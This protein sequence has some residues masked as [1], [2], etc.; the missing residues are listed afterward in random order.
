MRRERRGDRVQPAYDLLVHGRAEH[1][2]SS[3]AAAARAAYERA[4]TDE[5]I[6][7]TLVGESG[8]VI[9]PGDSVFAFNFRPDRMREITRAL[10]EPGFDEIERAGAPVVERY[11]TMT[12]Y[13]EDFDYPVAFAPEH[14]SMT[15]PKALAERG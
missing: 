6:T 8:A 15:L 11:A 10:A 5:F 9:R 1:L 4:E 14:P 7:P 2:A 13:E 3:G 12:Q